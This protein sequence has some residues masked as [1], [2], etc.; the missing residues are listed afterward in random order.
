MQTPT[1]SA[2]AERSTD[3]LLG[4]L[5]AQSKHHDSQCADFFRF[6]AQLAGSL[7][8]TGDRPSGFKSVITLDKLHN[9]CKERNAGVIAGLRR[10]RHEAR[11]LDEIESDAAEGRMT[12]PMDASLLDFENSLLAKR[13]SV[14]QGLQS[15]GAVKIRAIDDETDSG[16]NLATEG[17]G[18]ISCD[19]IDALI[20]AAHLYSKAW[21]KGLSSW[22]ADI[23]SA[24]RRPPI[25]ADQRWLAWIVRRTTEGGQA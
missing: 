20:T 13:F 6:G 11:L 16:L 21:E 24:Y 23:K 3:L 8:M 2:C 4:E 19:G 12:R 22:K 14:E 25:R 18:K 9:Q 7:P 10:D 1:R 15:D 17:G 5:A